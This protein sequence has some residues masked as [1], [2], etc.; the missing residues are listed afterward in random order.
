MDIPVITGTAA[1][2]TGTAAVITGTAPVITGTLPLE[3]LIWAYMSDIGQKMRCKILH[4]YTKELFGLNW[5][6]AE[7]NIKFFR[8][9][10]FLN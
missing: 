5:K 6:I 9:T 7:R 8:R 2:I 1:V 4:I 10:S 3:S